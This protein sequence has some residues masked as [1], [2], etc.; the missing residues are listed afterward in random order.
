MN[1]R[2]VTLSRIY[3]V[4]IFVLLTLSLFP[5]LLLAARSVSADQPIAV[6]VE[7]NQAVALAF[8]EAIVSVIALDTK[9][10][11]V[12]MDGPYLG[13]SVVDPEASGRFFPIGQ[14]GKL[15]T[16][17]F[18][19]ATPADDVVHITASTASVS[20]KAH[21]FSVASF[22]RALRTGTPIP[23]QQ[24]V[25]VPSPTLP[26]SR[27]VF[28]DASALAVGSL[29]GMTLTVRNTQQQPLS[30][31]LRIGSADGISEGTVALGTWAWPPRMT[32]K[33]VAA[34]GEVVPAEGQSRLYV[35]FEKR[36]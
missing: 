7:L 18:K 28:M 23:S 36:P 19:V 5:R 32:I 29:V 17:N 25:E 1:L 11:S 12:D 2:N 4:I 6:R 34:E 13:L 20:A 31:D 10:F 16:V 21:P 14:S 27:L 26:D 33:A 3:T 35:I 30:L 9:R 24:P 22:L 15:Y 8:P